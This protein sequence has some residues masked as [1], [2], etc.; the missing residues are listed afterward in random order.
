MIIWLASYPRMSHE[1]EKTQSVNT[2]FLENNNFLHL[3]K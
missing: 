3:L 1:A 2:I